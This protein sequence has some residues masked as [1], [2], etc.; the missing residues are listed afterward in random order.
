MPPPRANVRSAGGSGR[1]INR[2]GDGG[3]FG[4]PVL[5]Y[6][7]NFM[8]TLH[9]PCCTVIVEKEDQYIEPAI[10]SARSV[11]NRASNRVELLA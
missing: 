5:L 6:F 11:P 9:R 3:Q 4:N 1:R 7:R 2:D 8:G 10:D